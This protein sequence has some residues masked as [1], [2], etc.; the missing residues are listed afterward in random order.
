MRRLTNLSLIILKLKNSIAKIIAK[1]VDPLSPIGA[2]I[3]VAGVDFANR[4]TEVSNELRHGPVLDVGAGGH[5]A[6]AYKGF[7]TLSVDIRFRLGV[8]VVASASHLPFQK[9]AFTNVVSVDTI[10]HIP[11]NLRK[12]A[13]LEMIR[14]VGEKVVIHCPFENGKNFL[15]RKYDMLFQEWFKK[16]HGHP[17]PNTAEHIT[18]VEPHP[19]D[20]L[21]LKFIIKPKHNAKLWFN[22]MRLSFLPSKILPINL[23]IAWLC[24]LT[25][26]SKNNNPPYWGGVCIYKKNR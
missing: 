20:F 7:K 2:I 10:E 12:G 23:L 24:F 9:N 26:K 4:Y 3:W 19:D 17:D 16:V 18:N 6:L 11:R 14:V 5:S 8:D 15:G 25:H 22:Y 1:F 21:A 13:L